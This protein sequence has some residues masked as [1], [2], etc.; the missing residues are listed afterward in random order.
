MEGYK[1]MMKF[2]VTRTSAFEKKPCEEAAPILLHQ[3]WEKRATTLEA[4]KTAAGYSNWRTNG[5]CHRVENGRV[6]CDSK[7]RFPYWYVEFKGLIELCAF[8]HKYKRVEITEPRATI[9]I[10]WKIEIIDEE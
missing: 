3:R 5:T 6:V 10:N 2:L 9:G 4:A 1:T 8:V 7:D